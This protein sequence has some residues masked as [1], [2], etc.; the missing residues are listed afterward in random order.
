M[1]LLGV[2]DLFLIGLRQTRHFGDRLLQNFDHVQP[3]H[4]VGILHQDLSGIG[5][6]TLTLWLRPPM[7]SASREPIVA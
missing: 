2:A 1:P 4:T 6:F 5:L 3:Y 7:L